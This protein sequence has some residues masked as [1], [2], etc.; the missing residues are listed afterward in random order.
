MITTANNLRCVRLALTLGLLVYFLCF[1]RA[2]GSPGVLDAQQMS[3][4]PPCKGVLVEPGSDIQSVIDASP[5]GATLCV[6]PGEYRIE[7][8]LNPKNNQ[9]LVAAAPG[10]ILNGSKLIGRFVPSGANFVAAGFLPKKP[11]RDANCIVSGCRIEQDVFFD[12]APL[13]RV[14]RLGQL[15]SGTFYE[16]FPRN[17]I[18]LCDDPTG[19]VVEQAF[20]PRIVESTN[21]GITVQGFIVE[22]AAVPAQFG[23][24]DAEYASGKGWLIQNNEVR[25]N[26]GAG[27]TALQATSQAGGSTIQFNFVHHNGQEGVEGFGSNLLV[28]NNE[29]AFNNTVGFD[30]GW[31]AGGSKFAGF[32]EIVNLTVRGNY[33]HDN[34]GTGIWCDIDSYNVTI[35]GNTVTN[36]VFVDPTNR[37]QTGYGIFFEISDRCVISNNT[38]SGNGPSPTAP[39][40]IGFYVS[41]AIVISASPNCE[42]Y[43]NTVTGVNGIGMLQQMRT[44]SCTFQGGPT[45]PDGTPVCPGGFHQVHDTSIHDNTSTETGA[46]GSGAEVAGLDEDINDQ[47]FFTSKNNRFVHNTYHL[48][49]LTGAYFSWFDIT[50]S[51]DQWIADGQD[52]TGVFCHLDNF[53]RLAGDSDLIFK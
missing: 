36:N 25:Y 32:P 48:P 4:G 15:T 6:Q 24:I 23:A 50:V 33:V 35:D 10:T 49:S 51:K 7:T 34:F 30:P 3:K 40:L 38:L 20:A 37:N 47:S 44:D 11:A 46:A 53:G 22:K 26:H 52:T 43:G 27:I 41:G 8:A 13:K 5:E 18:Y 45:Y 2:V 16:D 21:S 1:L 14:L 28:Q 42:V 29:I 31:E 12:G 19:H 17:Q 39:D 9:K